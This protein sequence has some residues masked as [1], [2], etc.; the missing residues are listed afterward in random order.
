MLTGSRNELVALARAALIVAAMRRSLVTYGE[1]GRA[2]GMS[3]VD[4]RNNMNRVLD[5][6]S[7]ACDD[8]GEPSLAALVVNQETGVPG[9]GWTN[10]S[11]SWAGEVRAV[12]R[13]WKPV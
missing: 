5:D 12:Y 10:G 8:A 13:H 1:L 6:L 4:L 11:M 2:I 7:Q 9:A 3:G